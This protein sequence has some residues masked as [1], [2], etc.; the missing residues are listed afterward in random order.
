MP[1]LLNLVRVEDKERGVFMK[2]LVLVVLCSLAFGVSACGKDACDDLKEMCPKCPSGVKD[3]CDL[4]VNTPTT[5]S[6][7]CEEYQKQHEA[8]CQ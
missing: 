1:S 7:T 3:G 5:P 8:E 4:L 2:K 6:E